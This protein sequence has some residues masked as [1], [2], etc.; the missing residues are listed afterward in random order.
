MSK[1]LSCEDRLIIAKRFQDNISFGEIGKELGRDR[2]TSA[3]NV[4]STLTIRSTAALAILIIPAGSAF[5][6]RQRG[7]VGRDVPTSRLIMQSLFEMLCMSVTD[8]QA[9]QNVP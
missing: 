8:V 5:P 4:K 3:K 7:S 1:F 6:V 2:I 9:S